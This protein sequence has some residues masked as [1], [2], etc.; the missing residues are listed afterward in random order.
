MVF[1]FSKKSLDYIIEYVL[2]VFG[3]FYENVSNLEI[4][5]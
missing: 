2:Y 3:V 4:C 1:F 5:K